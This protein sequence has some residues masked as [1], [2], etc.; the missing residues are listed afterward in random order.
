MKVTFED[1]VLFMEKAVENKG[2]DF[3]ANWL[4]EVFKDM[5]NEQLVALMVDVRRR[6]E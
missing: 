5:P 3:A 6:L 2:V 1:L 4:R